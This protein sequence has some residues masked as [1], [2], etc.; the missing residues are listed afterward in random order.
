MT[1]PVSG[2]TEL[3]H[4]PK[5][6]QTLMRRAQ[7]T[8]DW[9]NDG[10]E[11]LQ[12]YTAGGT[13]NGWAMPLFEFPEA[14]RLLQLFPQLEYDHTVD[15]FRCGEHDETEVFKPIVIDCDGEKVTVYGIGAG[16]WCWDEDR[17]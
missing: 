1:T 5:R 2:V 13:W 11:V 3:G 9:L 17:A 12:G 15:E 4:Q 8:A 10:R 16:S 6:S 7:F 14:M